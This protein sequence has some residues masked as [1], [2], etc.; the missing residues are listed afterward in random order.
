M[1]HWILDFLFFV[2]WYCKL[3]RSD[4]DNSE[5]ISVTIKFDIKRQNILGGFVGDM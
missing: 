2:I 3:A 4:V 5:Y 1:L